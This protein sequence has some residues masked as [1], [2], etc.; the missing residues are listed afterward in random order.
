MDLF[1]S[2]KKIET[3][4]K[5]NNF[6]PERISN[7]LNFVFFLCPAM[8]GS[9]FRLNR[10]KTGLT[11][12]Y[13]EGISK[14]GQKNIERVSRFVKEM[15]KT[16]IK[17]SV[18]TIFANAD[19]LILFPVPV[20]EPSL[21]EYSIFETVGNY[22]AV[23]QNLCIFS[24]FYRERPWLN[25][26]EKFINTETDRLKE[27]FLSNLPENIVLDF[28]DRTFAGFALDGALLRKGLFGE[29][30]ILLGV[31]SPGVSVLQNVALT[32]KDWIPVVE[33]V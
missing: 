20:K 5:I 2:L 25:V 15:E 26:P 11:A 32:K 28:I 19:S 3:I 17:F 22:E 23:K 24:R 33:L 6:Y 14:S 27:S 31:E 4:K 9:G 10:H 29:N 21:P 7:P 30:P 18:T 12:T 13:K 8:N 16:E 1:S